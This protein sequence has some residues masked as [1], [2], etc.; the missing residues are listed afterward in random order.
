MDCK[1][2]N[3]PILNCN[4]TRCVPEPLLKGLLVLAMQESQK[5]CNLRINMCNTFFPLTIAM[6]KHYRGS[7]FEKARNHAFFFLKKYSSSVAW[8]MT[9]NDR[10]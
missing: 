5:L 3:R 2:Q 6:Y 4:E 9:Q 10:R 7:D 1:K 8:S